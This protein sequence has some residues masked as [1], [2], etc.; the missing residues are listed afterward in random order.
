MVATV[1]T[2]TGHPVNGFDHMNRLFRRM[3]DMHFDM[4]MSLVSMGRRGASPRYL[5]QTDRSDGEIVMSDL[6]TTLSDLGTATA[7]VIEERSAVSNGG[8]PDV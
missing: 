2:N 8:L 3:F 7:R 4:T 5:Q 6:A 1:R